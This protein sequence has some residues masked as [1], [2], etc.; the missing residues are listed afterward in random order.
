M[1]PINITINDC[2]LLAAFQNVCPPENA[3][4]GESKHKA[5][6]K[7]CDHMSIAKK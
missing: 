5:Q 7:I 2:A 4:S 1:I 6:D 3:A